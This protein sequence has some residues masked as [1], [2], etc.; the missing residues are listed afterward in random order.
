MTGTEKT[1]EKGKVLLFSNCCHYQKSKEQSN[2]CST[3]CTGKK[4]VYIFI[5]EQH[6]ETGERWGGKEIF[7]VKLFGVFNMV[8]VLNNTEVY[9]SN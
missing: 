6:T 7:T 8:N 3:K 1:P 4:N 9:I 5:S 2:V